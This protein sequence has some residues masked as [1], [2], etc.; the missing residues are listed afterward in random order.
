MDGRAAVLLAATLCLVA[1]QAKED[2]PASKFESVPARVLQAGEGNLEVLKERSSEE[3]FLDRLFN[4]DCYSD[5]LASLGT[6]CK[7]LGHDQKNRLAVAL[8]NCQ[9]SR[10]GAPTYRCSD[11]MSLKDC[12]EGMD[13]KAYHTFSEFFAHI[14]SMCLFL[15][16]QNFQ[17]ATEN[18]MNKLYSS[19]SA[20]AAHLD[21]IN[22]SL[23]HHKQQLAEVEGRVL[24]LGV[25]QEDVLTTVT[26]N[27][28]TARALES[29]ADVLD[30]KLQQTLDHGEALLQKQTAVMNNLA[31]LSDQEQQRAVEAVQHWKVA[32]DSADVAFQHFEQFKDL[33]QELAGNYREIVD[34]SQ[35]LRS[36]LDLVL[37]YEQRSDAVLVRLLGQSWSISDLLFY[38]ASGLAVI[39]ATSLQTT[40]RARIPLFLLLVA[41]FVAERVLLDKLH[42][43]LGLGPFGQVMINVPMPRWL[44][45]VSGL[46]T[47]E[48]HFLPLDLKKM[49]RWSAVAIALSYLARVIWGY[50]N[51]EELSYRA[52]LS[53]EAKMRESEESQMWNQ[54]RSL[55]MRARKQGQ[56]LAARRRLQAPARGA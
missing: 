48:Q 30:Q 47:D 2:V 38:A 40:Q 27:L 51:Y 34:H 43:W 32:A 50:R 49:V 22:S 5:A 1:G 15:Q 20:A 35:D 53:I 19:S 54:Q 23:G 17:Q 26:A 21:A 56:I 55:I 6:D 14:D 36:A 7:G 44:P 10:L 3:G 18:T 4:T 45:P 16:N 41:S 46:P 42:D 25:L 37:E 33:Q 24:D 11:S 31:E 28:E 12:V 29:K 13:D 9:L 52:V 8:A 39:M